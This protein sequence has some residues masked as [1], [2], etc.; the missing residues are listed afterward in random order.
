MAIVHAGDVGI[1]ISGGRAQGPS[2]SSNNFLMNSFGVVGSVV[3]PY[4]LFEQIQ[5]GVRFDGYFLDTAQDRLIEVESVEKYR[6]L[7]YNGNYSEVTYNIS[8]EYT[9]IESGDLILSIYD[10]NVTTSTASPGYGFILTAF[11]GRDEIYGS[12]ADDRLSGV[13]GNGDRIYG[14]AGDDIITFGSAKKSYAW[15]GA[16]DDLIHS[17]SNSIYN[18]NRLDG[19]DGDDVLLLSSGNTGVGGSGADLFALRGSGVEILD[20]QGNEGDLIAINYTNNRFL[21]NWPK[22][23]YNSSQVTQTRIDASNF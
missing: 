21:N 15:G 10:T 22:F 2:Y 11:G 17:R 1:E 16:G 14:N 6:I 8:L 20:F 19:G 18:K 5:D 13:A 9:D 23:D 3:L 7:S 12:S 4:G